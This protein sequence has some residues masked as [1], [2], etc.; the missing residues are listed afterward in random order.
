MDF[1]G[2][3]ESAAT[4]VVLADIIRYQSNIVHKRAPRA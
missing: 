1:G 4:A 3:F 2:N